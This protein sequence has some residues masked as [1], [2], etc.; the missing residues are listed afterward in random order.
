MFS[1]DRVRAGDIPPQF[2]SLPELKAPLQ[3]YTRG[4]ISHPPQTTFNENTMKSAVREAICH[5]IVLH[6]RKRGPVVG[7]QENRTLKVGALTQRQESG[8][9]AEERDGMYNVAALRAALGVILPAM[10]FFSAKQRGRGRQELGKNERRKGADGSGAPQRA[11]RKEAKKAGQ[12][13][14]SSAENCM[15][16]GAQEASWEAQNKPWG[17]QDAFRDMQDGS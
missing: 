7:R 10:F 2:H 4:D 14:M 9:A 12:N 13:Q 15:F 1:P 5:P 3:Y 17:A 16:R 8:A 6:A 11:R